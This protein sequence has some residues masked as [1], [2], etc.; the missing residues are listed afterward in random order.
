MTMQSD[1]KSHHGLVNNLPL[2]ISLLGIAAAV[3]IILAVKFVW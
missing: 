2:Q 3:L 1:N